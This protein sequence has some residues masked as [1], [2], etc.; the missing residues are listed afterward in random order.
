[1]GL[2]TNV[3]EA[4]LE[5]FGDIEKIWDTKMDLYRYLE[6]RK[7]LSLI[8]DDELSLRP[9]RDVYFEQLFRYSRSRL[10]QGFSVLFENFPAAIG[11]TLNDEKG[12]T[13]T[14]KVKIYGRHNWNN[15][16][17][18]IAVGA[19]LQVSSEDILNGLSRYESTINRS[20][21]VFKNTNIFYLDAYNANPTSMKM[22]LNFLSELEA[23][24]KIAIL[25]DMMELGSQSLVLHREIADLA[26]HAESLDQ[27]YFVGSNFAEAIEG[28]Y[29]PDRIKLFKDAWDVSEHL[30]NSQHDKTHFLVKGSRSMKLETILH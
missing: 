9:L 21:V 7:S 8:N 13:G 25:G 26:I 14:C 18:A 3:A 22:A 15:L 20:Q 17:S 27:I 16:L 12:F 5:G 4:H 1:M 28:Q 19:Y 10:P 30:R 2:V 29:L 24:K 11:V 23:S 6:S